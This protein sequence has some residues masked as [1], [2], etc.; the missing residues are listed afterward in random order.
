MELQPLRFIGEAIEVEFD[1]PPALEKKPD[2]PD[3]FVWN[4]ETFRVVEELAAWHDYARRGRMAENMRPTHLTGAAR[5]GSWGV[6]RLY[7]RVRTDAGRVFDIYYDRAP[8][9]SGGRKGTWF[10][11]REMA[12]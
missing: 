9:D 10:L 1:E 7:F 4:G 5:R 6:G 12:A 8:T 3:R 2:C 11:Y